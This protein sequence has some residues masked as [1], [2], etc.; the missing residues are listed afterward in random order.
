[1]TV[2]FCLKLVAVSALT[3]TLMGASDTYKALRNAPAYKPT[4]AVPAAGGCE[5]YG[6]RVDANAGQF[7][8]PGFMPGLIRFEKRNNNELMEVRLVPC[9]SP[10]VEKASGKLGM[11][12]DRF[13]VQ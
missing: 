3:S 11:A 8:C 6:G 9:D 12:R 10:D 13:C 2:K 4:G 1:M 7:Y 5:K